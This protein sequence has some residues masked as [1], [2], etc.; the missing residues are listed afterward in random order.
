MSGRRIGGNVGGNTPQN[1]CSREHEIVDLVVSGREVDEGDRTLRAHASQCTAC[2]ETLELA[3]LL[4]EDQRALC[5]EAPVPAAG[6]VWWR[7][8]IRARAEAARTAGQPITLLQGIAAATAVGLLVGLGGAWGRSI[9]LGGSWF[10]RVGD[11]V[12]RL[13]AGRAHLATSASVPAALGLPLLLA[14]AA[15]LI[16]APLAVYLATADEP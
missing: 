14:L 9:L 13:D 5:G 7:A 1:G 8:T 15:C 4:R 2:A 12:S 6:T 16:V 10:D 3:R 11:L